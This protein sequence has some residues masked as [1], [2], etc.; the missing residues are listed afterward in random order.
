MIVKFYQISDE[1]SDH[2]SMP[3]SVDFYA[4]KFK[5]KKY[6]EGLKS[7]KHEQGHSLHYAKKK[8]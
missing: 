7:G 4:Y 8:P 1:K 5:E 6:H 2:L 3:E